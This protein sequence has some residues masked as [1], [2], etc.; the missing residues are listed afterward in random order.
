MNTVSRP[1]YAGPPVAVAPVPD[2]VAPSNR[3]KLRTSPQNIGPVP[4]SVEPPLP[5]ALP[6][7]STL[8]KPPR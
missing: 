3:P 8:P 1:D 7:D 4:P 6:A 5:E 2:E